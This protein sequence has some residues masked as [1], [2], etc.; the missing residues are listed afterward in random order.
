MKHSTKP[1]LSSS[2]Y[3][4]KTIKKLTLVSVIGNI[5]LTSF[6]MIAGILG[7]SGAMVSDAIHSMSDVLTTFIAALGVKLSKRS[8]DKE[9]PYGHERLECVASIFLGVLL[10]ITGVLVG[11]SGLE[12]IISGE[13]A[14]LSPPTFLALTAAIVSIVSKEA[15]YWYTRYYAK[16]INSAAFMADAWHHRSDAISSVGSLIGIGGAMLGFPI[17]D[18]IASLVICLFILK[19]TYDILKDAIKKMLDTS[20]DEEYE[21]KIREFVE[22]QPEVLSVDSLHTRMFGNRIYVDLEIQVDGNK[23]LRDAHDIAESVHNSVEAS[24]ADVKHIMIHL[25]PG[26]VSEDIASDEK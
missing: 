16:R 10:G 3:E 6:K 4:I 15:M 7:H 21:R 9:H 23:T 8:S 20:C 19:V 22:G 26:T 2:Q 18:P 11:K 12:S 5:L 25:N 1:E 14:H 24:F 13:Y 17:C